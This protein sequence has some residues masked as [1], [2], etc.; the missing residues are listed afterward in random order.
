MTPT[1]FAEKTRLTYDLLH[2]YT[3]IYR[4]ARKN[5]KRLFHEL[6]KKGA[7]KIIF[8]GADEIAEIA[9]LTLQETTMKLAGVADNDKAGELFF[10]LTINPINDAVTIDHDIIVITSYVNRTTIYQALI[11]INIDR[12]R[13][14]MLFAEKT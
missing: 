14:H 10:S 11:D 6:E 13:I 5:L 1:G 8:A 3:R 12:A 7:K 2:D 4:E 9:Y